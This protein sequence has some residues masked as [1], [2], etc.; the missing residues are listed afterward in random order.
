MGDHHNGRQYWMPPSIR[1]RFSP[2]QRD[3]T[4]WMDYTLPDRTTPG[5]ERI[6]D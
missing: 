1:R 5:A 2:A 3:L 6:D 4:R